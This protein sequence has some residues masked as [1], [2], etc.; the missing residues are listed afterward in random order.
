MTV[1]RVLITGGSGFVGLGIT[2]ALLSAGVAVVSFDRKPALPTTLD[3]FSRLP[4]R[5]EI[6]E[7][8]I[9]DAERLLAAAQDTDA[10]IH[11]SAVTPNDANEASSVDL[12]LAVNVGGTV[13]AIRAA[14]RTR[15]RRMVFLGSASVY[16]AHTGATETLDEV[17]TTPSPHSVYAISKYAAERLAER[18]A[19]HERISLRCVRLGSVFGP[20]EHSSGVR[21]TLSAILQ[22]T[23]VALFG[24]QPCV[25][26]RP[27]RRDWVYSRDV[28]TAVMKVLSAE[29]P[30]SGPVNIGL[31]YEWTV[32]DWCDRLARSFPAFEY[33]L[34]EPGEEATVD[35][36]S[37][38][39]RPPL[40][41]E[42]L[43]G[44]IG[45]EPR[46]GLDA[47]FA[48]YMGWIASH[49]NFLKGQGYG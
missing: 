5:I 10:V 6:V 15:L 19:S 30:I 35:F 21:N 25:L 7:G 36:H 4:G 9:R 40:A 42:R 47:A 12:T 38:S 13:N 39:D 27:G 43:R 1:R 26:P 45:F 11:G 8:D 37:G 41:I 3:E 28:A 33:R 23:A 48:D 49:S 44:E 31:G 46:Y 2:E 29:G 17:R 34:A 14:A 24:G 16:G 20:W 32:A 22:T 18:L